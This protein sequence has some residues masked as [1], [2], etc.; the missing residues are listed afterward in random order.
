M[1]I[2]I[3]VYIYLYIHLHTYTCTL[4]YNCIWSKTTQKIAV[5]FLCHMCLQPPPSC[6]RFVHCAGVYTDA[7]GARFTGKWNNDYC[8][9]YQPQEEKRRPQNSCH[10]V[11]REFQTVENPTL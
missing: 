4:T 10:K 11:I 1:Y 5:S 3:Y 9:F 8:Y 7:A 2:Y 6:V